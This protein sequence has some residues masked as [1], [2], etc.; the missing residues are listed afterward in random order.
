[1]AMSKRLLRCAAVFV[2]SAAVGTVTMLLFGYADLHRGS[3]V[4]A[5]YAPDFLSE[6]ELY[7]EEKE[8]IHSASA[9]R[10]NINTAKRSELKRLEGIGEA[11]SERIIEYR[12]KHGGFSDISELKRVKGIGEERLDKIRDKICTEN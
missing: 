10:I 6:E 12:E 8:K 2:L 5:V 11:L 9:E 3:G 7:L 4:T 1:M